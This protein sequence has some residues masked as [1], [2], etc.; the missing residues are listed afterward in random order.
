MQARGTS[1]YPGFRAT[2]SLRA[3]RQKSKV[4]AISAIVKNRVLGERLSPVELTRVKW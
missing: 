2:F 3:P 1:L 4:R